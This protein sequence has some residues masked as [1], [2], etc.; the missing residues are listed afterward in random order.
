M[1]DFSYQP[2]GGN[3]GYSFQ[4][5]DFASI[6][7]SSPTDLISFI[8]G[9]RNQQEQMRFDN[10][11]KLLGQELGEQGRQFNL[12][13]SLQRDDLTKRYSYLDQELGLQKARD[14]VTN[15]AGSLQ[16]NA[17]MADLWGRARA[18]LPWV[19]APAWTFT[20]GYANR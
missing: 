5:P 10:Q 18:P 19:S 4:M 6:F 15:A 3:G 13:N 12:N 9:L 2:Y 8:S 20:S 16:N 1:P 17:A 7:G 14:A 11:S